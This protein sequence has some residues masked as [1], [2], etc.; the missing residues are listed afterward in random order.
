MTSRRDILALLTA[1]VLPSL[2]ARAQATRKPLKV[3][4]FSGGTLEDQKTYVDAFR[5]GMRQLGYVE[6]RDFAIDYFWRGETIKPFA[7][8]ARDVVGSGPD[9]ILARAR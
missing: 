1:S 7:W 3:A 6:G 2:A 5:A 9:V 4:W 8:L